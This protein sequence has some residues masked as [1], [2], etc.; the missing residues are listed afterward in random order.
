MGTLMLNNGADIRFIQQM[1]GH[2][3]ISTTEIYTHVAI[4]KLKEV[5]ALTHPAKLPMSGKMDTMDD[6]F[7]ALDAE[8]QQEWH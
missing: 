5:H 6:L 3:Q 2:S 8:A 1:L 4:Y 7:A